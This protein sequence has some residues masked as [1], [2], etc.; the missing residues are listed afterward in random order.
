MPAMKWCPSCSTD[1]DNF[2]RN[3]ARPD[4]L[5]AQCRR[6]L[7]EI[8]RVS[9]QRPDERERVRRNRLGQRR[10]LMAWLMVYLED[11]PCV[12]CPERDPVVLEFDH[13]G[14]KETT[15]AE[16]VRDGVTLSRLIAEVSK[17]DVRCANCHRR[18]TARDRGY[19][20][21]LLLLPDQ[22]RSGSTRGT[23]TTSTGLD[24]I[25]CREQERLISGI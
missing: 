15:V 9:R 13:R 20:R 21:F 2:G 25:D 3:R 6:C 8:N 1:T 5:Q 12:D 23:A 11:H 17:C 10:K 18:R 4:G 14:E 22:A 7:K 19:Y 24:G 16:L